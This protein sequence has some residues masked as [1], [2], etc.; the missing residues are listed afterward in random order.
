MPSCLASCSITKLEREQLREPGQGQLGQK[1][2]KQEGQDGVCGPGSRGEPSG[3]GQLR[4]VGV[5][6]RKTAKA[7]DAPVGASGYEDP[8]PSAA[9]L[10]PLLCQ[11]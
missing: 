4:R 3:R 1:W 10:K 8:V 5:R 6:G 7:F 2:R 11:T 9:K